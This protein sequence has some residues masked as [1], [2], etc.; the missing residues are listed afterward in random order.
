[1]RVASNS[2]RFTRIETNWRGSVDRCCYHDPDTLTR[3]HNDKTE[4]EQRKTE[5]RTQ[6]PAPASHRATSPTALAVVPLT[7]GTSARPPSVVV[8]VVV[9]VAVDTHVFVGRSLQV[10]LVFARCVDSLMTDES[11][12]EREKAVVVA[13]PAAKPEKKPRPGVRRIIDRRDSELFLLLLAIIV[14]FFI[15]FVLTMF[16]IRRETKRRRK[17]SRPRRRRRRRT[18]RDQSQPA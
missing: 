10:T 11:E 12:R 2:T 16:R 1:V 4:N 8:V 17:R 14:D 18:I 15:G 5:F 7:P 13:P 3:N 9:V 6:S